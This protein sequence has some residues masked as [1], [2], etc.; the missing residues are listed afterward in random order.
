MNNM[1]EQILQWVEQGAIQADKTDQAMA[2]V[3]AQPQAIEWYA[4]LGKLLLWLGAVSTGF[5]VIFFFAYNW[6]DL[7]RWQKFAVVETVL[8]LSAAWA[9]L[10]TS[11]IVTTIALTAVS[12]LTGAGLALF[13]QTY[14]TGADPWQL[15]AMW[16]V[17]ITPLALI[18]A[19]AILWL[20][21]LLLV[22]VAVFLAMQ[23]MHW[24]WGFL[25]G[26]V[27]GFWLVF[28]INA[29]LAVA[30]E[31]L[32][33]RTQP[34]KMLHICISMSHRVMAQITVLLALT[35]VSW[36]AA[37]A[38]FESGNKTV[39]GLPVYVLSVIAVIYLYQH[40]RRDLLLLAGAAF[41][42][43]FVVICLVAQGMGDALSE[44]LLLLIALLIIILSTLAGIWLKRVASAW[45]QENGNE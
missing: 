2:L 8:V 32:G 29:I 12:L 7:H 1:R 25:N 3:D 26:A 30:F 36:L 40:W 21:W 45:S 16:A 4:F 44:G 43:I 19:S 17:L 23:H 42:I 10:S 20:L 33:G 27:G 5:G 24:F 34:V 38:I 15:F 28:G 6:D 9:W 13:G 18:S 39:V 11:R 31:W 37:Y 22:H 35:A 41:S 14:Q